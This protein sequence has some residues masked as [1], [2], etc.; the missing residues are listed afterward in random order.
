[1]QHRFGRASVSNLVLDAIPVFI[2][3]M[4][5]E[6]IWTLR[7]PAATGYEK[8]DTAASLT[9]GLLS[10][11]VAGFAKLRSIGSGRSNGS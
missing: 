4:I 8:R 11:I 10:V 2:V 6:G 7:R 1:V 9:M 5:I 3:A